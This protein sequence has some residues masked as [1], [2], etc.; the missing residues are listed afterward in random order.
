MSKNILAAQFDLK[1]PFSK[2]LPLFSD[3]NVYSLAGYLKIFFGELHYCARSLSKCRLVFT[4]TTILLQNPASKTL[5]SLSFFLLSLYLK[6]VKF[7]TEKLPVLFEVSYFIVHT[8]TLFR[9]V[10][11]AGTSMFVNALA[12]VYSS[13]KGQPKIQAQP[14]KFL[15]KLI[16]AFYLS[17][18][19]AG[20]SQ[21]RFLE[22]IHIHG[23]IKRCELCSQEVT[24]HIIY[25]FQ[26]D[27]KQR[28]QP[29]L[30]K[31]IGHSHC[32]TSV[33]LANHKEV[34]NPPLFSSTSVLDI[35]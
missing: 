7:F 23:E 3:I 1:Y 28:H 33:A 6:M 14:E 8:K 30:K 18:E 13:P 22:I 32:V 15:A 10:H 27:I 9:C 29:P 21:R 5:F 16:V 20:I 35:I 24:R 4:R 31:S 26:H 12:D 34:R 2:K 19:P 25:S 11:C 17:L